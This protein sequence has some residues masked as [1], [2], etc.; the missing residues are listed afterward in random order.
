MKPGDAIQVVDYMGDRLTRRVVALENER[1]F[2]CTEEELQ[3][4][5]LENREPL[6]VGFP[7]EDAIAC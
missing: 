4:A 7:I 1:V 6:C 2:V 3:Q 5:K